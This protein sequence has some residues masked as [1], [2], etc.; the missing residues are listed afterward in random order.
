MRQKQERRPGE[1]KRKEK[2]PLRLKRGER[3][4]KSG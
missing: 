3:R 1:K 4:K 2:G